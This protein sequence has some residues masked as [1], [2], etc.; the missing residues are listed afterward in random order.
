MKYLRPMAVGSDEKA[1][2]AL[3]ALFSYKGNNE[4]GSKAKRFLTQD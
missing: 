4:Q 3:I 2:L 1:S